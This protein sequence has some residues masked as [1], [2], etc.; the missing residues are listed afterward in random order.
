MQHF[1]SIRVPAVSFLFWCGMEA[2]CL[3]RKK[4]FMTVN[5]TDCTFIY[6]IKSERDILTSVLYCIHCPIKYTF[7][8]YNNLHWTGKSRD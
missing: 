3:F 8:S 1:I 4:P 5:R 7:C 2:I 6:T